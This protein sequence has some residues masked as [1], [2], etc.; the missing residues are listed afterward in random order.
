MELIKLS[1]S[2]QS[3]RKLYFHL[4]DDT[5]GKTPE[6]GEAGGSP[7]LSKN[8]GSFAAATNT[9]V[10]V[11]NGTYYLDLTASEVDT[12][13]TLL[14]RYKST[15]TREFVDRVQVVAFDPC[16][17]TD[18][19]LSYLDILGSQIPA[20]S[21]PPG[22]SPT[23]QQMWGWMVA[24]MRNKLVTDGQYVYLYNDAGTEVG[25]FP[26]ADDGTSFTRS[27]LQSAP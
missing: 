13:G 4:V 1:E 23:P 20:A 6:T 2:Q 3:R 15:N 11:G 16:E 12:L 18:L 5:D 8:G 21:G 24:C 14:F 10:H 19:G 22:A 27:K 26:I 17:S 25:R 7:Q 9:L